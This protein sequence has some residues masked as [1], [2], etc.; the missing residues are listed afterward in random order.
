[1]ENRRKLLERCQMS[2]ILCN[3]QRHK[4]KHNLA[5][6]INGA[7]RSMPWEDCHRMSK[8][9]KKGNNTRS[10]KGDVTMFGVS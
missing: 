8:A 9:L 3:G 2:E 4:H 10:V 7:E 1:M 6:L 5:E